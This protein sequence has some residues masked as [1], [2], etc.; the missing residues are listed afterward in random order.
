M[1]G[2]HLVKKLKFDKKTADTSSNILN[3]NQIIDTVY[4]QEDTGNI[5][6]NFFCGIY[7]SW[8][9]EMRRNIDVKFWI[10]NGQ[11]GAIKIEQVWTRDEFWSFCDNVITECHQENQKIH[12]LFQHLFKASLILLANTPTPGKYIRSRPWTVSLRITTCRVVVLVARQ[13]N[14]YWRNIYTII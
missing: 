7:W 11:E 14:W 6:R 2:Y 8:L 10:F 13:L 9:L 12:H 4:I 1:K 5:E 3:W